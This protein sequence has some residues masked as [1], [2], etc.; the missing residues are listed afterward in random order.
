[1]KRLSI[2]SLLLLGL[3]LLVFFQLQRL[4]AMN[5][6]LARLRTE[7]AL[8]QIPRLPQP[9]APAA[10][11]E[12]PA[13]TKR[14]EELMRTESKALG[15]VPMLHPEHLFSDYPQLEAVFLNAAEGQLRIEYGG[16]FALAGFSEEK[17]AQFLE[18][19]MAG[20]R[21]WITQ[22]KEAQA[23]GVRWEDPS[24]Q[25][26]ARE[27]ARQRK[28]ELDALLGPEGLAT[29]E[30]FR[31]ERPARDALMAVARTAASGSQPMTFDQ[32]NRLAAVTTELGIFDRDTPII[33]SGSLEVSGR[34]A[35]ILTPE[36]QE[37]FELLVDSRQAGLI[38]AFLRRP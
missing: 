31:E 12:R 3:C 1:M 25:L 28:L 8:G 30:K 32:L 13:R 11:A 27:R 24:I 18:N 15:G 19:L 23:R 21:D 38:R 20:E 37:V 6:P 4:G 33:D 35:E 2:A 14:L 10:A 36:Q 7:A 29:W 34:A 26:P 5:A 16:F 22:V 17:T 9:A